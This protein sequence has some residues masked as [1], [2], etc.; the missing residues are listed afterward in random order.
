[1]H[2]QLFGMVDQ[3]VLS[4]WIHV[5]GFREDVCNFMD[6]IVTAE[7]PENVLRKSQQVTNPIPTASQPYPRV[8]DIPLDSAFCRLRLNAHRHCFT[9]WKGECLTCRMSYPRQLAKR[10][11]ISEIVP[12]LNNTNE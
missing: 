12:D 3:R 4:R 5:K 7:V 9:C 1:M 2:G 8:E 10:T 6:A 11:Y